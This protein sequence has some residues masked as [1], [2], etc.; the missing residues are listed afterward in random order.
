MNFHENHSKGAA[1]GKMIGDS[2]EQFAKM[3]AS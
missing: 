3:I 2:A 1:S